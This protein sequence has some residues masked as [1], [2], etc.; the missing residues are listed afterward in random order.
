MR[1]CPQCKRMVNAKKCGASAKL[2]VASVVG[3]GLIGLGLSRH[4]QPLEC[5]IC[6]T[7]VHSKYEIA[8][9]IE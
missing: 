8:G 6:G 2:Q 4:L 9:K 5:P 3:F 7:K 1:Y